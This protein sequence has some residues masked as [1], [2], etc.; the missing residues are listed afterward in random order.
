MKIGLIWSH[1]W[2]FSQQ[3]WKRLV[4]LLPFESHCLDWGYFSEPVPLPLLDPDT[5][6]VG[7]GHSLGLIQLLD[8]P[9]PWHALI[10]MQCFVDFLTQ[11]PVLRS[12]RKKECAILSLSFRKDPQKTLN[13]FYQRCQTDSR[14]LALGP[15]NFSKLEADLQKLTLKKDMPP[16]PFLV[17]GA[18]EDP[19][20][21]LTVIH[22][23]FLQLPQ[24]RIKIKPHCSTHV[25]PNTEA[26]WA[27]TQ[28]IHFLSEFKHEIFHHRY[29]HECR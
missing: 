28:I 13:A 11:Q 5:H 1:G 17:L 7:I 18:S 12:V 10:G 25:L 24:T 26:L 20:V 4:P 21:P 15:I 9:V 2:G 29:R 14:P 23:N 22:D 6:W 8:L 27:R 19:I 3:I 16:V